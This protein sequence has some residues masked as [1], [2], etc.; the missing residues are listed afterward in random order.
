MR[1]ISRRGL[2]LLP[3]VAL[4]ALPP[5]ISGCFWVAAGSMG[6]EGYQYSQKKGALYAAFHPKL[7]RKAAAT[8]TPDVE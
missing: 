4:L 5:A 7:P 1:M 6:Y 2:Q 8:P 3:F